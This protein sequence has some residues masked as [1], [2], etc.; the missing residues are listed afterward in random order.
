[1]KAAAQARSKQLYLALHLPQVRICKQADTYH[2]AAA[3]W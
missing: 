3:T 2:R 1:M